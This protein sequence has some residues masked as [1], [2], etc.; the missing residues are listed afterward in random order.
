MNYYI[1]MYSKFI[2]DAN[3]AKTDAEYAEFGAV[4][5]SIGAAGVAN[6]CAAH[7]ESDAVAAT[8]DVAHLCAA[9]AGPDDSSAPGLSV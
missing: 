7:V 5:A 2:A 9:H 1:S 3:D 6:S 8:T 4:A